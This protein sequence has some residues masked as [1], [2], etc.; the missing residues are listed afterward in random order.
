MA[1]NEHPKP[2]TILT[3]D[4]DQGF[5]V[6]EMVKRRLVV[7]VSPKISIRAGLCT[8][9]PLSRTPPLPVMPYHCKIEIRPKLPDSWGNEDRWVKG[10]MICAVGFHRL[11]LIRVGKDVEGKRVYRMETLP[12]EDMQR[13]R[14][15]ILSSL[16]LARLT[17][18]L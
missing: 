2:G 7:V 1:I 18:H 10:D 4:F 14:G 16:G 8:V 15:C 9:V 5:R 13:I 12:E 6:P 3:A 11:D 17:T